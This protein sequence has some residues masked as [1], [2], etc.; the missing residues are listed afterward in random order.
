M[1]SLLKVHLSPAQ[2]R[3]LIRQ[4]KR[5]R[6]AQLVKRI[7]AILMANAG[8]ATRQI[9]ESLSITRA[10][11]T[12]WKH[13]WLRRQSLEDQQHP[14]RPPRANASYVRR[15]VQTALQDPRELGYAFSRWTAP[16]L[17]EYLLE[18]TGLRLT[19]K[20]VNEL[21]RTHGIVW[22]KTKPFLG[23]LCD[24][25]EFERAKHRLRRL[26]K[27]LSTRMPMTSSGSPMASALTSCP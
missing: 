27:G 21:L 22:G 26:K 16:R 24:P 7:T 25:A 15:L 18:Q 23:N 20:W 2:K 6:S 5:T 19:P 1:P 12:N 11:L 14:G 10:T 8:V 3:A 17:A 9:L 13:R 4:Q